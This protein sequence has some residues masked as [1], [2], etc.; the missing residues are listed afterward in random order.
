MKRKTIIP[1]GM[2]AAALL[3]IS[4]TS[5]SMIEPT[6]DQPSTNLAL[7]ETDKMTTVM[8]TDERLFTFQE[9]VDTSDVII[10]GTILDT[11]TIEKKMDPEH[12]LP[13]IFTIATVEVSQ[14]LKGEAKEVIQVQLYGGETEDRIVIAERLDVEKRDDV[15]MFLELDPEN[16]LFGGN[17]NLVAQMQG[18]YK[19]ELEQAN[20]I[21]EER[22][23]STDRK[24]VV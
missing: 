4:I 6:Q 12:R 10:E 18:L 13:T 5:I 21:L 9:L 2:L 3:A 23:M 11:R 16:D 24:S 15:I 7:S 1:I 22:A 20:N 14:V 17:Y 19:I 8:S